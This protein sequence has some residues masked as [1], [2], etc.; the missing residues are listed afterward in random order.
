[1]KKREKN[2]S[3]ASNKGLGTEDFDKEFNHSE[4]SDNEHNTKKDRCLLS[5]F[6]A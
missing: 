5:R 1:M 2:S 6:K 3:E 4:E